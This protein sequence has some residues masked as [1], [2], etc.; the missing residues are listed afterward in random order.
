VELFGGEPLYFHDLFVFTVEELFVKVPGISVGVVT[1][2][3]LI[4]DEI[5][6][7]F[8]KR[9]VSILLSLDGNRERHD[10]LRGGFN[11]IEKWMPHL[12]H[13][14]RTTIAMQAGVISGL[15]DN[16]RWIWTQGFKRVYIN[17]LETYGWYKSE[18]IQAFEKE[19]EQILQGM[20]RGEG[21]LTCALQLHRLLEKPSIQQGC[22]IIWQGLACDW[23]GRLYPC[24]RAMEVG[25]KLSIGDIFHGVNNELDRSIRSMISEQSFH[26][27]YSNEFPLVSFCPIAVYQE[28]GKF[29]GSWSHTY[30]HM[31]NTKAKLVSKYYYEIKRYIQKKNEK[32][33]STNVPLDCIEDINL[34]GSWRAGN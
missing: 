32:K 4:T 26:S 34:P 16:I 7:L 31:I 5:I 14:G 12:V 28:H 21:D 3:T 6:S 19:Y 25:T 22:G 33:T 11:L 1:N 10:N 13:Q 9:R 18:C 24:H 2:G 20:L 15:Y 23:L 27:K 17:I 29:R 8:E 30:G